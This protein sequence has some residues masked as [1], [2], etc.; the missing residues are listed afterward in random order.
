MS[1]DE[2][3]DR[4]N[5]RTEGKCLGCGANGL[6]SPVAR[7][8]T[9]ECRNTHEAKLRAS[10]ALLARRDRAAL[11]HTF[12]CAGRICDD[13]AEIGSAQIKKTKCIVE[14]DR[15]FT[16]S[17][18]DCSLVFRGPQGRGKSFAARYALWRSFVE[19]EK[20]P[21]EVSARRL[22]R[23]GDRL[24]GWKLLCKSDVILIDDLDKAV[25]TEQACATFW[26]MSDV[27][28]RRRGRFLLTTNTPI[29]EL[30]KSVRTNG[31][32]MCDLSP[33]IDRMLPMIGVEAEGEN[34]RREA[35]KTL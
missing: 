15:H 35:L 3:F 6:Y 26:E 31:G 5:Q 34:L 19:A 13:T 23:D 27:I 2:I 22:L 25:W 10:E 33:A 30:A 8:C 18:L 16:E 14:V 4:M 9:P 24:D 7:F 32:P 28:S 21:F 11:W 20:M 17:G 12:A 29:N 1:L